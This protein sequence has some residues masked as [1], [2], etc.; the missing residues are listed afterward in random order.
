MKA[1]FLYISKS[2]IAASIDMP[3]VIEANRQGFVE[4]S[5]RRVEAPGRMH[6]EVN[7]GK[8][9]ALIMP[10]FSEAVGKIGLKM[11]TLCEEN[12]GKGEV[13]SGRKEGRRHASEITL[14]KSVG[15]AIQD[16]VTAELIY[17]RVL[18]SGR[19]I[20]LPLE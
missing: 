19:G 18:E 3:G 12:P 1:S 7:R 20:S 10:V 14:F 5:E 2:D 15:N 8:T 4:L 6:M 13:A 11:A 17:K 16:L 9:T